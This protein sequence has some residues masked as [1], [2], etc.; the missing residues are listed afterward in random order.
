MEADDGPVLPQAILHPD[1]LS[2]F[3]ES[4]DLD[5]VQGLVQDDLLPL[6]ET[7]DV[8]TRMEVHLHLPSG[9]VNVQSVILIEAR[10]NSITRRRRGQLLDLLLHRLDLFARLLESLGQFLVLTKRMIDTP[11]GLMQRGNLLLQAPNL[12][13]EGF[14]FLFVL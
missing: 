13:G 10:K 5:H 12:S 11:L 2:L 7:L 3:V 9:H 1:H 6:P 14:D 8:E 4:A